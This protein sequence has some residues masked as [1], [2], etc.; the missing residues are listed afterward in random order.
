[1]SIRLADVGVNFHSKK[2]EYTPEEIVDYANGQSVDI[3]VAISN[4]IKEFNPN[5]TLCNRK[6]GVYYTVGV[7]P[8]SVSGLTVSKF[9]EMD[10][11][12]KNNIASKKIV[13][14]GECGLDYNRMFSKKE[15]Q[16]YW[17]G[18]QLDLVDKHNL[19]IYLHS[20]EAHDDMMDII[21]RSG[22]DFK[23]RALVHCFTGPERELRDYLDAGFY[24]SIGGWITDDRR[25][26]DLLSGVEAVCGDKAYRS[27][28]LSRLMIETD[29]PWLRPRNTG[30]KG[31]VN[32]PENVYFVAVKFA[33]ITGL[34]VEKICEMTHNN[35]KRFFKF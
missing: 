15:D 18:E 31:R 12:I 35:T 24:V 16:I 2:F 32:Y 33:E 20:R 25:N 1:M 10:T 14:V 26:K 19:P 3:M 23:D 11:F 27:I 5:K 28:F 17:F 9:K 7:H 30:T 21:E 34:S 22:H 4:S 6:K 8:H 29:S 13:A